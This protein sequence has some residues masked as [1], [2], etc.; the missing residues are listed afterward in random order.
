VSAV[1]TEGYESL[2]SPLW[3]DTPRPDARNVLLSP[4]EG[5]IDEAGFRF[6]DDVN[7][8]GQGQTSE[9]GLILRGDD[10]AADFRVF[11]DAFGTLWIEPVFAG[12]SVQEY[13]QVSDL[14]G[15]D[16]APAAGYARA[17]IQAI[18][19]YGYVFEIVEGA[20]VWYGGLR[21]S[22]MSRDYVIFDWSFQTD[23]GNPEL[24][25]RGGV[26]TVAG[27]GAGARAAR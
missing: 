9:L 13:G 18:P 7:L 11:R 20:S 25:V 23:P 17:A 16:F 3:Q 26:A 27:R 12:T 24:V 1:S 8:D 19:T 4:V 14:T 5:F 21:V 15:I 6:W 22:H 10:G 2:W